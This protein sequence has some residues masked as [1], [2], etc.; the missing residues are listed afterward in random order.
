[1]LLY[2]LGR[3]LARTGQQAS[4]APVLE[5]LLAE[6]PDAAVAPDA[7]LTLARARLELRQPEAA[8]GVL[9]RLLSAYPDS[10]PAPA[11]RWELASVEYRL[12]RFRDATLAFRQLSAGGGAARLGGLYWAGRSLDA[13]DE[14]GA[15]L[16]RSRA[17]Q[18]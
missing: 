14:Q 8:R 16:A 10:S 13:T 9:Q 15:A 3:L 4:A 11:A 1:Q 12:G 2:E 6:F 7:A 17:G 18:S 5:Q